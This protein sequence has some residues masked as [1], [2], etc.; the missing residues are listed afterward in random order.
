VLLLAGEATKLFDYL[1]AIPK[2]YV[3]QIAWGAET[4]T[5]DA[6]GQEIGGNDKGLAEADLQRALA[7]QLGWREQVPPAHSNVRVDGERAYRKAWRGEPVSL[8]AR[9]V[10]LHEAQWLQHDL[11]RSSTLRLSCRGGY[12]VRALAR[13]LGRALGCGA[14]LMTLVREAVGPW[15]D[16]IAQERP[17]VRGAALLPWCR[18]REL[19][20]RDHRSL[21]AGESIDAAPL[22]EPAWLLPAG[23]PDPAAPVLGVQGGA[24]LAL[25]DERVGRLS[26]RLDLRLPL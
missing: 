22:A 3:A 7:D 4:D 21:R 16:P 26:L 23:F 19:T 18:S 15:R 20:E 25:L 8:P 6:L 2:T 11:P 9:R 10:Y 14:H 12:Y 1:H 17:H 5:G 13:D 24:L